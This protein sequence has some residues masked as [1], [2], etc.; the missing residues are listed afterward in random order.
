[1][2]VCSGQDHRLPLAL[3]SGQ[4]FITRGFSRFGVFAI[5][6]Q[7]CNWAKAQE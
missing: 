4:N 3:A 5:A 2:S 6:P 7:F 1:M